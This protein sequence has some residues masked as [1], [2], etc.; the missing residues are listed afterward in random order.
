[1]SITFILT[2]PGSL[3]VELPPSEI[4]TSFTKIID[5]KTL[6]LYTKS[7]NFFLAHFKHIYTPFLE[8]TNAAVDIIP[9]LTQFLLK[10]LSKPY[11]SCDRISL[12]PYSTENCVC[13]GH[14]TQMKSTQKNM[15]CTWPMRKCCVWYQ[16]Q[17][18]FH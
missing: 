5:K 4:N 2:H 15:K 3:R 11:C 6:C 14:Q 16:T 10:I 13:V 12:S 8:F 17:P 9:L 7:L 18:I 1:M